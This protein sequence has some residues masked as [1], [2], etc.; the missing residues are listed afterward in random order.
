MTLPVDEF[1]RRFLQHALSS[2]SRILTSPP[3]TTINKINSQRPLHLPNLSA[4]L[5]FLSSM[6]SGF[7]SR[8]LLPTAYGIPVGII[9]NILVIVP[10]PA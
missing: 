6:L 5:E 4:K 3:N 9:I 1:I 7:T 10:G 8:T 2:I